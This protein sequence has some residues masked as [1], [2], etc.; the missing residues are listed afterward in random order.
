[1]RPEPP[2]PNTATNSATLPNGFR[3]L[4]YAHVLT[5]VVTALVV[6]PLLLGIASI[7][8]WVA[9]AYC[10]AITVT[11]IVFV[12]GAVLRIRITT[13]A[14]PLQ[15]VERLSVICG[16]ALAQCIFVLPVLICVYAPSLRL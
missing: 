1:M 14:T 8:T 12:V 3:H 15:R 4:F 16:L 7:P 9:L 2:V 6:I 5:L 10:A 13:E 11:A